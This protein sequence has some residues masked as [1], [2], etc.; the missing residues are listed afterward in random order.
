M[1]IDFYHFVG[2]ILPVCAL[3]YAMKTKPPKE[4]WLILA[5]AILFIYI[6]AVPNL[7]IAVIE[8]RWAN[9]GRHFSGSFITLGGFILLM[10][11][12][13]Q[14]PKQNNESQSDTQ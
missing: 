1:D 12:C 4:Q 10:L 7:G 5:P 6:G 2:L 11:T 8:P 13:K 3:V 14:F 9:S